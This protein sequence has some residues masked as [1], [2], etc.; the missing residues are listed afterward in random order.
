MD[1]L[2]NKEPTATYFVTVGLEYLAPPSGR[3][4]QLVKL[5]REFN[6]FPIKYMAPKYTL[7]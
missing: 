3:V 4:L 2:E 7:V 1:Y 6:Q 5:G